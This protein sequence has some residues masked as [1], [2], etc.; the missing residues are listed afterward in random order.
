V[1]GAEGRRETCQTMSGDI[2]VGV[3][4]ATRYIRTRLETVA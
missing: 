3:R 2:A 1:S 4:G